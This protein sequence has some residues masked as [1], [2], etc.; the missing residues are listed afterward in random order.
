MDPN[1]LASIQDQ[2][3]HREDECRMNNPE[4]RKRCNRCKGPAHSFNICETHDEEDRQVNQNE[5]VLT[6][7]IEP[8]SEEVRPEED[9]ER[10]ET[11]S[12][13]ESSTSEEEEEEEQNTEL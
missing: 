4:N 7:R 12:E 10:K 5:R 6:A 11:S 8:T 1:Q 9:D 13:E 3:N 2:N